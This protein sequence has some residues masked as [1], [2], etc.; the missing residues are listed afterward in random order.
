MSINNSRS[1][2]RQPLLAS[3]VDSEAEVAR[4]WCPRSLAKTGALVLGL[5]VISVLVPGILH[6]REEERGGSRPEFVWG[7]A[8]ASYQVEGSRNVSGRQP[9]IWDCFDTQME[10]ANGVACS[11]IRATKPN[12]EPN[13]FKFENASVADNDYIAFPETVSELQKFGFNSY[14]MSIAWPRVMSYTQPS[15][16]LLR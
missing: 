4:R 16:P 12:L 1:D 5:V 2:E 15:S 6:H 13:V 8:T 7:T 14:R 9:S 3:P 11:A 10:S